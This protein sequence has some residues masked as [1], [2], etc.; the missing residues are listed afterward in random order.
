MEPIHI[1]EED[2]QELY[3]GLWHFTGPNRD[4]SSNNVNILRVDLTKPTLSF[5]TTPWDKLDL[6]GIK[7]TEFLNES[8][9]SNTMQAMFAIN[10]NFFDMANRSIAYGLAVSDGTM[11]MIPYS[12]QSPYGLILTKGNAAIMA[13][14][15]TVFD[16]FAENIAQRSEQ[17]WT[18]VAGDI[19][20]VQAEQ[21]I[22]PAPSNPNY[23]PAVA[24]R[25]AI[26]LSQASLSTLP[27]YLYL[28][29]I[30]GLEDTIN[31]PNYGASYQDTANWL[32]AAGATEGF[33]LD[34]GGS[35]TM[36][37]IDQGQK[38]QLMNVPHDN[39]LDPTCCERQVAISFGII[40][41]GV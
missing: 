41:S 39:H 2:W 40:V 13:H 6:H 3:D 29:T 36:A 17:F 38:A 35:T 1:N 22:A 14:N 7:T 12:A 25:T 18:A 5:Y 30:D 28:L 24:A 9:N 19:Y 31:F 11:T 16:R 32:I 23:F 4:Y 33:N 34:G 8:F 15:A 21:S 27:Q 37:R 10:A 20:L 26:G